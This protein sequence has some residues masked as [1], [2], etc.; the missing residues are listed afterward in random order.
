[1]AAKNKLKINEFVVLNQALVQNYLLGHLFVSPSRKLLQKAALITIL[2]VE[3][4]RRRRSAGNLG[5]MNRAGIH[6]SFPG[7]IGLV[8]EVGLGILGNPGIPR[9]GKPIATVGIPL[10]VGSRSLGIGKEN[11]NGEGRRIHGAR[12]GSGTSGSA[13]P[14]PNLPPGSPS[15]EFLLRPRIPREHFP[16]SVRS[17][18]FPF[19]LIAAIFFQGMLDW[20]RN[21][22]IMTG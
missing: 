20:S 21:D 9:H 10:G 17:L 22:G 3:I 14:I 1:M 6:P 2:A 11:G 7:R 15:P 12:E 16:G 4:R 8:R 13:N 18:P 19:P 5:I